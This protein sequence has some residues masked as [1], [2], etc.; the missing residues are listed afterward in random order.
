MAEIKRWYNKQTLFDKVIDVEF[1]YAD[2]K[3]KYAISTPTHGAKPS[4]KV[5]YSRV[6][7]NFV[8]ELQL[9]IYNFRL[10]SD[11]DKIEQINLV[12][13]YR[14]AQG[15]NV[16]RLQCQTFAT[17]TPDGG[18]DGHTV[19]VCLVCSATTDLL[20]QQ[21]YTLE[22][23]NK[24]KPY[25]IEKVLTDISRNL[26]LNPV[27]ALDGIKD[28]VFSQ[29]PIAKTGNKTGYGLV[30]Y[31]ADIINAGLKDGSQ[32]CTIIF[33]DSIYWYLQDSKGQVSNRTLLPSLQELDTQRAID[34]VRISNA[35][36]NAG[37]LTITAPFD[38]RVTPGT[39]VTV[40]PQ[41]YQGGKQLPN[42]VTTMFTHK[43]VYDLYYVITQQVSFATTDDD[44]SMTL[45]CV[46]YMNSPQ[47]GKDAKVYEEEMKEKAENAY[48][49]A[50]TTA[51]VKNIVI[52]QSNQQA[53]DPERPAAQQLLD[54]SYAFNNYIDYVIASGDT[55]STVA[56]GN[57]H[58]T[59]AGAAKYPWF[60]YK[61]KD[62]D[63]ASEKIRGWC[64]AYPLILIATYSHYKQDTK[65]KR[66]YKINPLNPDNIDVDNHLLLPSI[67]SW[68][69]FFQNHSRT[70][71]AKI[72][73][74]CY[75][76]YVEE[77]QSKASWANQAKV[78]AQVLRS[79]A[80]IL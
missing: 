26:N 75:E 41:V 2:K 25:T 30:Q 5:S 74:L 16:C 17:Y 28:K 48:Q 1:M 80:V 50:K 42:V 72:F 63:I 15:E 43:D 68:R 33:N 64:V 23:T 24:P 59:N 18:P 21:Q 57:G 67:S 36:W 60:V 45:L 39:C 3:I 61:S 62:T 22:V 79:S 70:Q 31:C 38:P 34:L 55:L 71:A 20:S 4:I 27:F 14:N 53:S 9:D 77:S 7:E 52:E 46:P 58:G 44:N 32:L 49:E 40:N 13:G 10:Q 37:V 56:E 65:N 73:E 78:I 6:P 29:K 76:Y 35:D 54:I 8:Y 66:I 51:E 11:A 47:A 69:L 12:L 19:F